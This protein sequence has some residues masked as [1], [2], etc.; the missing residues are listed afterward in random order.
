MKKRAPQLLSS[1]GPKKKRNSMFMNRCPKPP[2]TNM[3]VTQVQTSQGS[4]FTNP[5]H[6][7]AGPAG[8]RFIAIARKTTV[9][10]I[11][12]RLTQG[13]RWDPKP[14][15]PKPPNPPGP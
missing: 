10:A 7:T 14:M 1:G 6:R 5:S 13:V 12:R 4:V 15:P 11:S 9:F 3:Y 2:C 8:S